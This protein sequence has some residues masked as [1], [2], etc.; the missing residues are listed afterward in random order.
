MKKIILISLIGVALNAAGQNADYSNYVPIQMPECSLISG[1]TSQ[2]HYVLTYDLISRT[3]CIT[4]TNNYEDATVFDHTEPFIPNE[5]EIDY[6]LDFQKNMNHLEMVSNTTIYPYSTSVKLFMKWGEN[7][8]M[9]TGVLIGPKTVLTAGHCIYNHTT[10]KWA[11][12]IEVVPGYYNGSKPFGSTY[13]STLRTFNGWASNGYEGW[14]IG[15]ITV[16]QPIG[17]KTGSLGFGCDSDDFYKYNTFYASGFPGE[18]PY[19]GELMYKQHGEF[20]NAYT[21]IVSFNRDSYGGQSGSG[22]FNSSNIVYAILRGSNSSPPLTNCARITYDKFIKIREWR[23]LG[24]END[25][26]SSSE[27]NFK[28]FPNPASDKITIQTIDNTKIFTISIIDLLGK[29]MLKT[30]IESNVNKITLPI[31]RLKPGIYTVTI[32]DGKSCSTQNFIKTS[33]R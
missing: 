32:N 29:N 31:E 16:S 27:Y 11:D 13:A 25:L 30:T 4:D 21:D 20:D 15:V 7:Y 8:Y 12:Q 24:I 17:N 14:D 23:S 33:T 9:G 22:Y 1:N 18:A 19:N 10:K 26:A 6:L 28:L 3:E 2:D 5:L